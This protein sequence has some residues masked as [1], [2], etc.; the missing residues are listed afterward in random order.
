MIIFKKKKKREYIK[1]FYNLDEY[2][3]LIQLGIRV[4]KYE[5]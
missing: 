1:G 2:M 5:T 3:Y 4:L